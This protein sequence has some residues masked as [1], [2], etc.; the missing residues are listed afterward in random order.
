MYVSGN[1]FFVLRII[2]DLLLD[3]IGDLCL[4]RWR[5][6]TRVAACPTTVLALLGECGRTRGAF[7]GRIFS[8]AFFWHYVSKDGRIKTK[9]VFRLLR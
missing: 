2:S 9:C 8:L 6:C 4:V 1:L 3:G 7:L 5:K